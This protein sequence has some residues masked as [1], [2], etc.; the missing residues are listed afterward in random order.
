ME[1]LCNDARQHGLEVLLPEVNESREG[2]WPADEGFRL[3][4]RQVA[5]LGGD[6]RSQT[7]STAARIAAVREAG[8]PFASLHDLMTRAAVKR[9]EAEALIR[10]DALRSFGLSR[11]ELLWQLG[12][13]TPRTGAQM[14]LALPTEQDMAALP[15]LTEW[16]QELWD[17]ETLGLS[18]THP[19]ALIRPLLNESVLTSRHIGGP[20]NENRMPH[21]MRVR[22]AGMVV[23]RQ[24]P[25]TASGLLFMSLEDE[26]GMTNAV[27]FKPLQDRY[28][29]LVFGTGFVIIEGR[30]DN[31]KSGFP[32]V[33]AERFSP[34]PLPA[35]QAPVPRSHDFA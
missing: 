21:G 17:F 13:L 16:D 32:H 28:R 29:E 10:A 15:P 19:M 34:C 25:V 30:V 26:W 2:A 31:E 3:G 7:G 22:V 4:L 35:G 5:R 12:L 9:D 6:W 18:S 14:P 8:G 23:C 11:R 33:I 24:R 27:V 20:R 1:T